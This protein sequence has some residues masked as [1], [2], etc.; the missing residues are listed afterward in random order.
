MHDTAFVVFGATGAI[1]SATAR[2][3]VAA[4]ARVGLVGKREDATRALAA[5]LAMPFAVADVTASAQVDAAMSAMKDQLGAIAG[6]TSCVGSVLLKPAHLTK[7]DEL[8]ATIAVNLSSSFY[9]LRAAVRSM[10]EQGGSI[11]FCSTAAARA[12]LANHEA[13]AAAKSGVEG[14]A[15]TAAATY[16]PRN[17][18][19]NCVAPGLVPSG[20]TARIVGQPAALAASIAMHALGRIGTADE[21]ARAITWLLDPASSWV[22]AQVLAVDGGLGSLRPVVRAAAQGRQ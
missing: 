19:V 13:I 15:I 5:E 21:V 9:I 14:M 8:A 2:A 11:V 10:D 4:G 22:T 1:G 17:I 18:R 16:A 12:G 7:D 6:V 20:I 3:L